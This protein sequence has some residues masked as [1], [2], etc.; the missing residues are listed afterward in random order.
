MAA[1]Q[2]GILYLLPNSLGGGVD[3]Y[4]TELSRSLAQRIEH[5]AIEEIKSARRLLRALGMKKDFEEVHFYFLNE[6]TKSHE[7]E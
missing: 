2:K 3:T 7:A 4:A 1:T 5:F 6:H